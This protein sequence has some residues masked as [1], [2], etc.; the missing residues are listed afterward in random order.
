MTQLFRLGMLNP[1][2]LTSYYE[3]SKMYMPRTITANLLTNPSQY[4]SIRRGGQ[5]EFLQPGPG[6]VGCSQKDL[7][8]E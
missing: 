8:F 4:V 7:L 1:P 3:L 2:S 6:V 5:K